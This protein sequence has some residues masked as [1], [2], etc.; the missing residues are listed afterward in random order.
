MFG[1]KIGDVLSILA[2][3]ILVVGATRLLR[4]ALGNLRPGS[5]WTL[6]DWVVVSLAVLLPLASAAFLMLGWSSGSKR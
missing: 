6:V 4:R 1:I 2:I 5:P 3:G